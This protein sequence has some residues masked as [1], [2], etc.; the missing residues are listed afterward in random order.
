MKNSLMRDVKDEI[1]CYTDGCLKQWSI[2]EII[3]KADM[4][5]DEALFYKYKRSLNFIFRNDNTTS[6]CPNCSQFCQRQGTGKIVRCIFCTAKEKKVFD[7]CWDCKSTWRAGHT[8][9]RE[10]LEKMQKILNEA[11]R[12]TLEYSQIANV[13]SKRLCP[14]CKT[15]IEH[16]EK[17]KQM[18]CPSCKISFCFSC[19]KVCVN[20]ILQC[21]GFNQKCH[22]SPIQK[23]SI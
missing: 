15:L 18:Q 22:V 16:A 1:S 6:F 21:T 5:K 14:N 8:C 4:T 11:T 9:G 13:P 3:Q 2:A 7:F 19:L 23:V 17:C 10:A 12:K 20:D